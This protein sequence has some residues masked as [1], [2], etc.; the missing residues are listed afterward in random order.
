MSRGGAIQ[1][2]AIHAGRG[3]QRGRA[4]P[5]ACAPGEAPE[6]SL[7]HLLKLLAVKPGVWPEVLPVFGNDVEIIARDMYGADQEQSGE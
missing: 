5:Y 2:V 6:L 3:G 1:A 7:H 4:C